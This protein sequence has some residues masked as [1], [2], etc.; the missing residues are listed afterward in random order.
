MGL[1]DFFKDKK[2]VLV[3]SKVYN[4]AGD[5][6]SR[7][8]YLRTLLIR[9]VLSD[10]KDSIGDT[11][12][13]G[14]LHG[15]GVKLR[16]FY[17]WASKPENYGHIGV[18][19]GRLSASNTIDPETVAAEIPRNAG[20]TVSCERAWVSG[21][22]YLYWAEQWILANQGG[23][24]NDDWSAQMS[25]DGSQITITFP[26]TTYT[27]AP[28]NFNNTATYLYAY[29]RLNGNRRLFI[30][31]DES[32]NENL[33]GLTVSTSYSGGFFP[34]IPIRLNN[35]FLSSTYLQPAYAQAARAY[36][37]ATNSSYDALKATL[38]S[39]AS[40]KD[41]DYI[42]V[43]FGVP[44]NTKEINAL[45]YLYT[46]FDSIALT[47]TA[48]SAEF[49]AWQTQY[50]QGSSQNA[51]WQTWKNAQSNPTDPLY[52]TPEPSQGQP[53]SP[54]EKSFVVQSNGI[55][56]E[57]NVKLEWVSMTRG[58]GAG[59]RDGRPNHSLWFEKGAVQ[60]FNEYGTGT[61]TASVETITLYWQRDDNHYT[62]IE[63]KGFTHINYVFR[64]NAVRTKAFAA[65][66]DNEDSKFIIPLHYDTFRNTQM[67]AATQMATFSTYLVINTYQVKTIPWWQSGFFAIILVIVV[68]I[69]VT[70]F[71]GGAGAG[72]LGANLAVGS[73]LG[74]TGM[75]AAIVGSVANALTALVLVTLI[76]KVAVAVFG[77][78]IGGIIAAVA[79]ILITAG[80]ANNWSFSLDTLFNPENILKITNAVGEGI[81]KSIQAEIKEISS[82]IQDYT[83][84]AADQAKNIQEQ[85]LKEFGAAGAVDP[86][87]FTDIAK[88]T[89]ESPT[90][91][92]QRTLLTGTDIA[93]LSH[94]LLSNFT[95][96]ST[97]LPTAFT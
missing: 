88:A 97:K 4:L 33:D 91:F 51:S 43:V 48:S 41:M 56:T 73:A 31:R 7:P 55:N 26:D 11:L 90:T 69:A 8:N 12:T 38:E 70:V 78:V 47:Q 19:Q 28:V 37:R 14:Y 18:P 79:T 67:V 21:A 76:Q 40:I 68:A 92:L 58:T 94:E 74:L 84:W 23:R 10:T 36:K 82:E 2:K 44:L 46:F 1:F 57:F 39:N 24:I 89:S 27:F 72:L 61:G 34:F 3:D 81:N 17:K 64:G 13:Q 30:Y 60:T 45:K 95:E 65:L 71:T 75:T 93:E 5:P 62:F 80:V 42:Y 87:W 20:E 25:N 6:S 52:G 96:H 85:Y 9:N 35:Q 54:P 53:P 22:E 63:I 15:P 86:M 77:D 29:Y 59:R 32:G 49:N 16:Q 83:K 50:G 66:D